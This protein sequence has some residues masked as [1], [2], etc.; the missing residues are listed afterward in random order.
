MRQV[1]KYFI[2]LSLRRFILRLGLGYEPFTFAPS[3]STA[4]ED[5]ILRH[6]VADGFADHKQ[7]G[8]YV[9]VGAYHPVHH[10][11]TYYFYAMGWQ[12]INID[13]RPGS[14][15]LFDKAR[16]RDINLEC[17]VG[18]AGARLIYHSYEKPYD[19]MSFLS[20]TPVSTEGIHAHIK[21]RTPVI[22]RSLVHIFDEYLSHN[23]VIDF[24]SVD[25]EGADLKVLVSNDWTRYRPR[26][27]VTEGQW[28][29]STIEVFMKEQ[30]YKLCSWVAVVPGKVTGYF[31]YDSVAT[32]WFESPEG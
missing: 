11:N 6:L 2:P 21:E 4:G 10:S 20:E 22:C 27:V 24:L 26:I 15:A 12:G 29:D 30:G 7:N 13:A 3:F 32:H 19:E 28:K 31:F 8:F 9:D 25:V 14:K 5:M 16:P 1:I 23:K 18:E 17:A